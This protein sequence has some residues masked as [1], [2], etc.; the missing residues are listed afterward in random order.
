MKDYP[1]QN[2]CPIRERTGDGV[3]VGRCFFHCPEGVC[4][5]H[6]DVSAPLKLYRETGKL[7]DERDFRS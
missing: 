7:T 6:G 2:S 3:S 5:R 4:P 1:N